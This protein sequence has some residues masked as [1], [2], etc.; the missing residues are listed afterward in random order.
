[1][2]DW[3]PVIWLILACLGIWVVF[4]LLVVASFWG[5]PH[6]EHIDV[7]GDDLETIGRKTQ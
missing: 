4:I 2:I 5:R 3:T 7:Y 1:M 6:I